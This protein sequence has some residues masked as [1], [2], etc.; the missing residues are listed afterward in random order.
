M[1]P[2]IAARVA[3][4]GITRLCHFTPSRNLIHILTGTHGILATS[5]LGREANPFTANDRIRLD[6][7]LQHVCCSIE[8]PNAWFLDVARNLD[9]LFRDWSV[10]T[11]D[12]SFLSEDST[13]FCPHNAAA[14]GGRHVVAGADGFESLFAQQVVAPARR[15]TRSARHLACSPTD[16]QAEV[17][18]ADAIP[19]PRI[20]GVI[21]PTAEQAQ[22]E[23]VRLELA[24]C[25][26]TRFSF[27]V[28]PTVFNKYALSRAIREGIRPTEVRF[29]ERQA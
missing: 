11:V 29:R 4:R 28:A 25:D 26:P 9:E 5:E 14:G 20:T 1:N 10:V 7:R 15:L 6:R 17:L 12:P 24:G 3:A 13:L 27:M 18:V 22:N 23:I 21:V 2:D 8:Y 16:D 19:L